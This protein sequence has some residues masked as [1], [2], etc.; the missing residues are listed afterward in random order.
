MEITWGRVKRIKARI[1]L[2]IAM[3]GYRRQLDRLQ[4]VGP[5]V[6]LVGTPIHDNLGDHLLALSALDV[7]ERAFGGERVVIEIP[8]EL[9]MLEREA[10]LESLCP[11]DVVAMM[12]GGWMGNVWPSDDAI[13]RDVVTS[14]DGLAQTVVVLPQT[15]HYNKALPNYEAEV[16]KAQVSWRSSSAVLCVRERGSY[17]T[18]VCEV[19]MPDERVKLL[20]DLGLVYMVP[21]A[22]GRRDGVLTCLRKDR[23][24]VGDWGA[25]AARYA[26]MLG[27]TIR[28]TSTLIG[29]VT[30]L[31]RRGDLVHRKIREF[32]T[33]RLVVTDRLHGMIMAVLA[34]T[35]CVYFDNATGKVGGVADAWL[36]GYPGVARGGGE[37]AVLL[38]ERVVSGAA[39]MPSGDALEQL[40]EHCRMLIVDELKGLVCNG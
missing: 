18:A 8:T 20:P 17:E 1:K 22:A 23:E 36:A 16:E 19:G 32:A 9:Y 38:L 30:P 35:P 4:S 14:S 21:H 33:A 39:G 31:A 40:Q 2:Q 11:R 28:S 24:R 15:L 12:A 34:G 10:I 13:L 6:L 7:L 29:K 25:E 37:D 27:T 26:K 3:P 5:K